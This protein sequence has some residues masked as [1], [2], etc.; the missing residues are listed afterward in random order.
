MDNECKNNYVCC[1]RTTLK[2]GTKE[3]VIIRRDLQAQIVRSYERKIEDGN[4]N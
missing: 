2:G 1:F 4:A 3:D